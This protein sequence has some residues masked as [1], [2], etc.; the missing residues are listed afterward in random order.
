MKECPA[1]KTTYT[2][3][4]LRFCLSDGNALI[5]LAEDEPTVVRKI[6]ND[7]LRV[8]VRP[9]G[10]SVAIPEKPSGS[11]SLLKILIALIVL[12]VVALVGL[13]LA[14]VAVYYRTGVTPPETPVKTPSPAPSASPTI[15]PETEK[16]RDELANIQK[17]LEEQKKTPPV[18]PT[19]D[20]SLTTT[21]TANSPDDGFLALRSQPNSESGKRILKIPHGAKLQIGACG[22]YITTQKNNYGRWCRAAY[23]GYSGWVFDK[24]VIY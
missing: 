13:G 4:S 10:E 3:D 21:V 17:K 8:D 22:D 20:P 16:L 14:G 11:S 12:G 6:P 9:E 15:D 18:K 19:P 5:S 1:C 2:D 7:A 23:G 24:Y